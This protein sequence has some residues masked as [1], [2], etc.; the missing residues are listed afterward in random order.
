MG[1]IPSNLF[2]FIVNDTHIIGLAFVGPLV[3][4]HL[5][6]RIGFG[7]ANCLALS[8]CN[9]VPFYPSFWFFSSN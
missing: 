4:D 8:M 3:F 7:G 6:I 5:E 2:L 9:L 1:L